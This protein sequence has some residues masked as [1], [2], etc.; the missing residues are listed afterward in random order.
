MREKNLLN[1]NKK[2]LVT[3]LTL[4]PATYRFQISFYEN[5]NANN[6]DVKNT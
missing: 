2:L 6:L 5:G 3:Y 1:Q 4:I